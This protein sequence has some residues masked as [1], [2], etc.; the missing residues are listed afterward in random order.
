MRKGQLHKLLLK[1]IKIEPIITVLH[2]N[3][4]GVSW[5]SDILQLILISVG[6]NT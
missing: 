4:W 3:Q 2:L 6:V 5:Q 1:M